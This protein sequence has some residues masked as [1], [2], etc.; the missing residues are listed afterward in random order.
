MKFRPHMQLRFRSE[1]QY[2]A[3]KLKASTS[4]SINEWIL[5]QIEKR[6]PDLA[7]GVMVEPTTKVKAK[8]A[9]KGTKNDAITPCPYC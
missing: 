3:I 5:E 6:N 2:D 8:T 7:E 1:A 4:P 9:K